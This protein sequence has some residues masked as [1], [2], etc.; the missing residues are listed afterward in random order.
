MVPVT[1][2]GETGEACRHHLQAG[3]RRSLPHADLP[4]RLDRHAAPIPSHLRAALRSQAVLAEWF[5]A[6]GWA[7]ILPSRRGRG[8]SE[9]TLRRRLRARPDAGL[10]LRSAR[11]RW[12]AP[13]AR[14][15]DIDAVT[16]VLLAQPFVDRGKLRGR[17][18]VARRHP[19]RRLERPSAGA[20]RGPSST[21]SAAGSARRLLD[22]QSDQPDA[23][24]ARRG[25]RLSR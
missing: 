10:H 7:V 16:P 19:R 9:G 18:P 2:D 21:S 15:R 24:Q 14:L 23:V 22:R 11:C 4:S 5:K 3:R 13:T 8:G 17:R 6:R 20:C 1:V 25:L 12:P